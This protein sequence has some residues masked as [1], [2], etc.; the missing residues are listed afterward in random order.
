LENGTD[1]LLRLLDSDQQ[2]DVLRN[3]ANNALTL[4]KADKIAKGKSIW[5]K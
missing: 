1:D 2:K 3:N 5:L 4:P